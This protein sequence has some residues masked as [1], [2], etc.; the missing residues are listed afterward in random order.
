M[1]GVAFLHELRND[2][3]LRAVP[4]VI[5]TGHAT[6]ALAREAAELSAPLFTKPADTKR[7][8]QT[9]KQLTDAV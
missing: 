6:P 4:A 2:P 7:L 5:L 1:D 3:A 8:L 9:I